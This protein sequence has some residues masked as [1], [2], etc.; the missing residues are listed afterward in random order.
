MK[1]VKELNLGYSDA[2]NYIQRSNKQMFS[3]VFVKNSYLD[4]LILPNI[5]YLV[6]EKGTGKTAFA[7]FLNNN[8]YK[9]NKSVLK[10]IQGTDY[11]KFY[12]LKKRK[13]IDISGYVD[14]W[15]TILLLLLAKSISENDRVV[16]VFTKSN[17]NELL[18]AIDEYYHNAFAPEILNALKIVDKSDYKTYGKDKNNSII[19]LKLAVKLFPILNEKIL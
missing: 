1:T 5:Y 18:S 16:S 7:V 13:H 4:K 8:E 12:E 19:K 2:Q 14:I 17:I 6:G 15:K 3:E 10:Y 11:E 9:G